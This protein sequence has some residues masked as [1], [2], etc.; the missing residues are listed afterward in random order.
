MCTTQKLSHIR[1]IRWKLESI[2]KD[3]LEKCRVYESIKTTSSHTQVFDE[4]CEKKKR[5]QTR[6]SVQ[7]YVYESGNQHESYNKGKK[8]KRWKTFTPV[9]SV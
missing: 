6:K 2:Q 7:I 1:Y 4:E 3:T 5:G 8:G 9:N